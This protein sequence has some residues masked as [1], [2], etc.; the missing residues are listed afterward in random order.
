[1]KIESVTIL[2]ILCLHGCV[3]CVWLQI[4]G[5]DQM[6]NIVAG[7]EFIGRVTKKE[8]FGLSFVIV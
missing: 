7:H 6:G 1:M 5:G 2:V 8:V 4:G 3:M